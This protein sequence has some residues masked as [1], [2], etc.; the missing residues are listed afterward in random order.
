MCS[1]SGVGLIVEYGDNDSD[2]VVL[3]KEEALKFIRVRSLHLQGD[4]CPNI[5]QGEHVLATQELQAKNLF[6]DAEVKK[7]HLFVLL[8]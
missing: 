4:D 3:D 1:P 8:H 7:V 2:H 5:K 6:F